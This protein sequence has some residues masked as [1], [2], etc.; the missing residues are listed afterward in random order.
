M[1]VPSSRSDVGSGTLG[2]VV[3]TDNDVRVPEMAGRLKPSTKLNA[4]MRC[5]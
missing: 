1:P 5:A 3:T 4:K 2:G